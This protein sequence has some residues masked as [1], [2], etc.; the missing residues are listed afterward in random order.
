M[1]YA[2]SIPGAC[3][4]ITEEDGATLPL[5]LDTPVCIGLYAADDDC[6]EG[7]VTRYLPSVARALEFL[8]SPSEWEA[9][10]C[11]EFR[12]WCAEQPIEISAFKGDAVETLFEFAETLTQSQRGFLTRFVERWEQ[13]ETVAALNRKA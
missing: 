12:E 11:D 7:F 5:S 9:A 13:F 10:L 4:W 1:T 3:V 6:G 2:L 8:D